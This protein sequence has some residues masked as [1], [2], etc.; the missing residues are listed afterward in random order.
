MESYFATFYCVA[1]T[2]MGNRQTFHFLQ[3]IHLHIP[4]FPFSSKAI[5][6][7]D[8][9]I[10]ICYCVACRLMGN[11]QTFLFLQFIY[12]H[13]QKFS[14]SSK[15]IA[16]FY[17]VACTLIGPM[18]TGKLFI[19]F[20]FSSSSWWTFSIFVFILYILI[21]GLY[22]IGEQANFSFSSICS[23]SIFYTSIFIFFNLSSPSWWTFSN[24]ESVYWS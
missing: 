6:F 1:C 21:C 10:L 22:A 15:A 9:F 20:N 13:F 14:F 12:L 17:C 7:F 24:D 16:F 5:I 11:R 2:L 23:S 8:F 3:L 4:K 18:G 19:F